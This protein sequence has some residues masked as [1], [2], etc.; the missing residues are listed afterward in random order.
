MVFNRLWPAGLR[1]GSRDMERAFV[2]KGLALV[3]IRGTRTASTHWNS[4]GKYGPH[5]E[6][7][8]FLKKERAYGFSVLVEFLNST[9]TNTARTELHRLTTFHHANTRG[10]RAGRL[11]IAHLCVVKQLSST[12]RV[13]FLAAPDTVHNH[14]FSDDLTNT[15]ATFGT[16]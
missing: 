5:S 7:F 8:F 3:W 11:R 13:W 2:G 4:P 10:S 12:C 1:H 14:K 6:L 15:H 16:R 9:P